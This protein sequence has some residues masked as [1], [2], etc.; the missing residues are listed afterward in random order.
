MIK[1]KIRGQKRRWKDIDNWVEYNRK[2]DMD[3]LNS[4]GHT[5][6]KMYLYPWY[7]LQIDPSIPN[8]KGITKAK[9]LEGL[10]T[11]YN[12]WKTQLDSLVKPYYLKI[13]LYEPRFILSQVVC[14]IE[15][16]VTFYD[17]PFY[18]PENQ[19]QLATQN[20]GRFA[21]ELDSFSWT[22]C[23]DEEIL[24]EYD[25]GEFNDW[26]MTPAAYEHHKARFNRLLKKPHRTGTID[27]TLKKTIQTYSFKKGTVWIG[28]KS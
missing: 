19:K 20:F 23:L 28:N 7:S 25:L 16:T 10:L 22:Y 21:K 15:D 14:A 24:T 13:W 27:I 26:D 2:I 12:S 5:Y 1:K 18:K 11:I 17:T 4:A 6:A 3:Y 9:M 8:P